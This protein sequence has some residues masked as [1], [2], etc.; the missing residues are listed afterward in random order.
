MNRWLILLLGIIANLAQGVAYSSSVL[1]KPMMNDLLGITEPAEIK[2]Y[3]SIIF[4][5]AIIFLPVGMVVAGRLE[6][7]SHRL[8]IALG[9][10][11]YGTGVF[12]SSFV[13]DFYMLCITFGF[14]LSFGAGLAYGP[15]VAS[16]VRWF[17]DRKGLA[18][19]LVVAALGFG[20]VWIAPMCASLLAAEFA[21][22]QVL[23]ILGAICFAAIG[24]AVLI[25]AAP[26]QQ[27]AASA[28]KGNNLVWTQMLCTNKF[29]WLFVLFFLGTVPGMMIIS[30]AS[31]IFVNIGGFTPE[32]AAGLVAILAMGNAL[33]RFLWGT[34]SDYIGRINALILMYILAASAMIALTLPAA[35]IP[36][37]LVCIVFVIGITFGGYLG[38]FPSLCAEAFG[39]KNMA[40]NYAFLFG[41]FAIAAIV[42]PRIFVAFEQAQAFYVAVGVALTGCVA[43]LLYRQRN[44]FI[45]KGTKVPAK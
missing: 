39:L 28:S 3:F 45:G 42:G 4:T 26:Q 33:G 1:S 43:A 9:A 37:V 24:V 11:I 22:Q 35:S 38:L 13:T 34:V 21:V 2:A 31:G 17:P 14:A 30:A 32:K 7:I 10:V 18:S 29:W 15:I 27:G 40:M 36:A 6:R 41:A 19:G 23:Q 12:T 8:P 5:L 44:R 25:P 16:A 20:P